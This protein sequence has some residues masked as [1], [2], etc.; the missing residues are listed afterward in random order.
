VDF[1][2]RSDGA[3]GCAEKGFGR[4]AQR[5]TDW[6]GEQEAK[7]SEFWEASTIIAVRQFAFSLIDLPQN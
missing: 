1:R 2:Q 4:L 3:D 5:S 7:H 6:E